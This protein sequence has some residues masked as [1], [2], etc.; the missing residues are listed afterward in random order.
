MFAETVIHAGGTTHGRATEAHA[1]HLL[2]TAIRRGYA[3]TLTRDGGASI[4]W[5]AR[6]LI[7]PGGIATAARSITLTP[8]TPAGV[9]TEGIRADLAAIDQ[10]TAALPLL[11]GGR[12]A[13][14]AGLCLVGPAATS[15][16]Y[17]RRLVTEERGRVRLTL[18]AHL[19][20]LATR[21]A[22]SPTVAAFFRAE[23]TEQP[24]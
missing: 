1:I 8:D 2:R 12:L 21:D 3:V 15:R 9:L 23:L 13:I 17:G 24:A 19:A 11:R 18:V 22:S 4:T 16:L 10:A 6:R 7:A 20:L 14:R 5:T